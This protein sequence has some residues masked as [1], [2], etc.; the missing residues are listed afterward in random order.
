MSTSEI[1]VPING[2]EGRYEISNLGRIASIKNSERFFIKPNTSTNY[3]KISCAKRP[4]E[5]S[6]KTLYVHRVVA[7][8]FLGPRP[9]GHVIR[10]LDGN[11]YNNAVNNLQY[12]LPC[13]NVADTIKHKTHSGSNNGRAILNETTVAAVRL[14]LEQKVSLSKIARSLNVSVSTIHAIKTGRNWAH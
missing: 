6:Q 2:Y 1:W 5:S 11:R 10:H 12:G 9:E 3:A 13:E 14:L 7:Q 4:H 8:H